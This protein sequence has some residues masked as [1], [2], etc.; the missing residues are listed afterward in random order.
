VVG[1]GSRAGVPETYNAYHVPVWNA[2]A[3]ETEI[4]LT[5][6]DELEGSVELDEQYRVPADQELLVDLLEPARYRCEIAV[7]AAGFTDAFVVPCD[8][9]D[10]NT[11]SMKVKVTA[12]TVTM[13]E[14]ATLAICEGYDCS[15]DGG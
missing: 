15:E 9:F 6:V 4:G 7:P 1:V 8:D 10:C 2:R 11:R 12:E 13:T 5:V 3:E 14:S